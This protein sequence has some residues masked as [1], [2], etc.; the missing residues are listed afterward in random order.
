M[1]KNKKPEK[2]HFGYINHYKKIKGIIGFLSLAMVFVIYFTGII[3]YH[4][5]KTIFTVMAAVATL[6]AAKFLIAYIIAFPYKSAEKSIYD[7]LISGCKNSGWLAIDS[8]E[9][10][11]ESNAEYIKD[12]KAV[13]LADMIFTYDKYIMYVDYI[14][15]NRG[16]VFAYS[17]H[18]KTDKKYAEGYIKKILDNFCNYKSYKFYTEE[19]LFIKDALNDIE[20]NRNTEAKVLINDLVVARKLLPYSI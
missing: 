7:S 10:S 12:D 5:N 18:K 3:I 15:I 11:C 9:P 19:S 4:S 14:I 6:P 8:D 1:N 20:T 2:G 17:S 13:L 16:H